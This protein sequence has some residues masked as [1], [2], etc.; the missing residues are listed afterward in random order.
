MTSVLGHL[1]ALEFTQ[2]YR[3]WASCSPGQL[4]D[5]D[6]VT[7]VANVHKVGYSPGG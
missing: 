6:V 1:T 7:E 2:R 5:A 4:F 3:K